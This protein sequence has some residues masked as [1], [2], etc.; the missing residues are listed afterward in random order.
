VRRAGGAQGGFF[1]YD[2]SRAAAAF[3]RKEV[4]CVDESAEDDNELDNGNGL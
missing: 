1:T 3:L 4:L 2:I